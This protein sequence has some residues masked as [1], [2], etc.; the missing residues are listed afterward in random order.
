M[1]VL[2][3]RLRNMGIISILSRS[4]KV[5]SRQVAGPCLCFRVYSTCNIAGKENKKRINSIEESMRVLIREVS[6]SKDP[7]KINMRN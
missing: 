2:Y 7:Q 4:V 3:A 5:I 6:S 1:W